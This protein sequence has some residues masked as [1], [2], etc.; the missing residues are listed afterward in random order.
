MS[1][2]GSSPDIFWCIKYKRAPQVALRHCRPRDMYYEHG[3]DTHEV[4]AARCIHY[5]RSGGVH[6]SND[7]SIFDL[8][9][10]V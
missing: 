10:E 9:P 8:L 1:M 2:Y 4:Q 3:N 7:V 6:A 5:F